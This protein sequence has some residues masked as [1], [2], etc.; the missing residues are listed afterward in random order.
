MLILVPEELRVPQARA[1]DALV[2]CDYSA[3]IVLGREIGDSN[4]KRRQATVGVLE[5]QVLLMMAH[6]RDQDFLRQRHE[7]LVDP[8]EQ[9]DRPLDQTDELGQQRGILA[10]AQVLVS[11]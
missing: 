10:Q 5:R 11:R 8:A 2:A 4:E 1:Q 3:T 6:R 7:T 9:G